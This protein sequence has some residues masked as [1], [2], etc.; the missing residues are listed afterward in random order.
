MNVNKN[1]FSEIDDLNYVIIKVVNELKQ[2]TYNEN[3]IRIN[4]IVT[5][6]EVEI[7]IEN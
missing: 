3:I 2:F 1:I 5:K 4:N 6:N 7:H